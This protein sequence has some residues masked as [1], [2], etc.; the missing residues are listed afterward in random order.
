MIYGIGT[1]IVE[2]ARI[3]R[4]LEKYG[5][6]FLQKVFHPEEVNDCLHAANSYQ[7][8]AARFAAKEA[9]AKAFGT[10]FSGS[11]AFSDIQVKN[12]STETHPDMDFKGKPVIILHGRAFELSK[13]LS[14]S[15]I[16]ITLSHIERY[17]TAFAV[18][19]SNL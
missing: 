2:V 11:L 7:M 6:V 19:E 9:V 18:I 4:L 17:A 15:K 14:F 8:Y 5:D 1:D 12:L 16:H 10:G 3:Q 13:N